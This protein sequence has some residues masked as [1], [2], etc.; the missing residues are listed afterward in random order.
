MQYLEYLD[1]LTA[2]SSFPHSPLTT[3]KV[4]HRTYSPLT[5][6]ATSIK[7]TNLVLGPFVILS[8]TFLYPG[9][10]SNIPENSYVLSALFTSEGRVT[11]CYRCCISLKMIL[12]EGIFIFM[13]WIMLIS[14]LPALN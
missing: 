12:P 10:H 4:F 11:T 13:L 5:K 7:L 1:T 9:Y 14:L 3:D 8:D 2:T 6:S